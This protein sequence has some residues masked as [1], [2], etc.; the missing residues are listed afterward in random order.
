MQLS[1]LARLNGAAV[2]GMQKMIRTGETFRLPSALSAFIGASGWESVEFTD[3]ETGA[4]SVASFPDLPSWVEASPAR[5][6]L[7]TRLSKLADFIGRPLDSDSAAECA[8]QLAS[9]L[10]LPE[11]IALR[12]T[13]VSMAEV[14]KA[15]TGDNRWNAVIDVVTARLKRE[16]GNPTG[17]NQ[18][19]KGQCTKGGTLDNIQ[20]SYQAP[21]GT[22]R[23]AGLRRLRKYAT[24][25]GACADRGVEQ[26][27]AEDAYGAAV[28]GE[29]SVNRALI[30]AGL[31]EVRPKSIW[32]GSVDGMADR[33][34]GALGANKAAE[35]VA[36]LTERLTKES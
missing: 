32:I 34:I 18:H 26:Q 27:K 28:R 6:G 35:L 20:G 16:P 1:D 10:P 5:G 15:A 21:T 33:I 12:P 19:T 13:L 8:K 17:E 3:P 7:G 36:A 24:D 11:L 23:E 9:H 4:H 2:C 29:V 31:K 22:S 25:A 14:N 30:R